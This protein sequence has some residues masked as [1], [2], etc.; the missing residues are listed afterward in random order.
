MPENQDARTRK[1]EVPWSI[2]YMDCQRASQEAEEEEDS[3]VDCQVGEVVAKGRR[4]GKYEGSHLRGKEGGRGTQSIALNSGSAASGNVHQRNWCRLARKDKAERSTRVTAG[5]IHWSGI[6]RVTI[7][8][9]PG[10]QG[11]STT[12][13]YTGKS[14]VISAL[15]CRR[16]DAGL[17]R[18]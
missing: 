2:K 17:R 9:N 18:R 1:P 4:I 7:P 5:S 15:L 10:T 8:R 13:K 14:G 11:L 6:H 16:K 12:A 3:G